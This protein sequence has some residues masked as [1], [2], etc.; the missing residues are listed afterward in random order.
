MSQIAQALAKAKERTGHTSVPFP[1]S[2]GSLPP[3]QADRVATAAAIR[4]AK[5]RQGF[6]LILALVALPLTGFVV[7]TQVRALSAGSPAPTATVAQSTTAAKP[8]EAATTAPTD[9]DTAAAKNTTA[10]AAPVF[11]A[12]SAQAV[13]ALPI[14]AVMPGDPA[15]IMLAGR[16]VRAGEAVEGGFVFAGIAE[17]ELRFTDARGTVYTRRY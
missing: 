13:Q 9:Q 6:W 5:A 14:S 2:G 16:V 12:E 8:T 7:W 15:R 10:V 17:G 4:K 1:S 3:F 11:R